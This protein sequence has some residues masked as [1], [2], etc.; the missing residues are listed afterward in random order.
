MNKKTKIDWKLSGIAIVC[1]TAIEI[2]ALMN[3]VNG[4]IRT[5]IFGLIALIVGIQMHQLKAK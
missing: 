2:T 3:G 5:V 1:L 4:T